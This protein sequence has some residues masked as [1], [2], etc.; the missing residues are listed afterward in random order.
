ME[1]FAPYIGMVFV[2]LGA[3]GLAVGV[4]RIILLY[5]SDRRKAGGAGVS[6]R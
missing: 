6:E 5:R 4:W 2:G 1:E 3:V